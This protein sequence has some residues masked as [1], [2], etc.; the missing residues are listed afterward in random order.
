MTNVAPG[1]TFLTEHGLKCAR[2]DFAALSP[3]VPRD[4]DTFFQS[5]GV[6]NDPARVN[7]PLE[8][9]QHYYHLL[10][11]LAADDPVK[12]RELHKGTAFYFMAWSAFDYADYERAVFFMDV[13]IAEDIRKDPAEYLNTPAVRFLTLSDDLNQAAERITKDLQAIVD[14][15][16]ARFNALSQLRTMTRQDLIAKLVLPLDKGGAKH[17]I[18]T[19][20]YTFL[21]EFRDRLSDLYLRGGATGSLEPFLAHLFKGGLVLESILKNRYPGTKTLRDALGAFQA[22]FGGQKLNISASTL[23]E[24]VA[25]A[26]ATSSQ[27]G[28][29]CTAGKIRNTTGHDLAWDDIFDD[30]TNYRLLYE[31]TVD[32]IL[33]VVSAKFPLGETNQASTS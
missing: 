3:A 12:Y 23:T 4:A 28:A 21:L 19:S 5:Y 6:G 26:S 33:F 7:R 32:A 17:G 14:G 27:D 11:V 25:F 9:F 31:R 1:F 13:A 15:Q 2:A 18:V 8:R 29:L 22:E 30:P 16:L 10:E 24:I 20:L